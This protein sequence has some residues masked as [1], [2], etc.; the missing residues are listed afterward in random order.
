V[1]ISEVL[2]QQIPDNLRSHFFNYPYGIPK[3]IRGLLAGFNM[4]RRI[5]ETG[6]R[7]GFPD[8]VVGRH[9]LERTQRRAT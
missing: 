4:W 3:G 6:V 7:I 1:S 5:E 8:K 2:A 9:Y